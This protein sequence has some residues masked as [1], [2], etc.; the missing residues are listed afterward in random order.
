MQKYYELDR[1]ECIKVINDIM[2]D[3]AL[4]ILWEIYRFSVN[5]TKDEKG[6]AA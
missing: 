6:G 2:S 3:T 4:W 5:I 1:K